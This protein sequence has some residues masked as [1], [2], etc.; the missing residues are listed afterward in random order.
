MPPVWGPGRGAALQLDSCPFQR[1]NLKLHLG[2]RDLALLCASM[3]QGTSMSQDC[4][5]RHICAVWLGYPFPPCGL[6][7]NLVC[8]DSRNLRFSHQ[9]SHHWFHGIK[10]KIWMY[11]LLLR[12]KWGTK[13]E[14]FQPCFLARSCLPPLTCYFFFGKSVY[15]PISTLALLCPGRCYIW[16]MFSAVQVCS[17]WDVHCR[18][19]VNASSVVHTLL[20]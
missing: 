16:I 7:L 6:M 12:N 1:H 20:L 18:I 13:L 14:F 5:P 10:D 8:W 17:V 15:L 3:C 19:I 4:V 2:S 9:E 11:S